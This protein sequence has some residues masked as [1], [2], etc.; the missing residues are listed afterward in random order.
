LKKNSHTP[1]F[2]LRLLAWF[3]PPNLYESIEGDLLEQFEG[4]RDIYGE[5]RAK[6]RLAW[7]VFLFFKLEII[8]RNRFTVRLINSNMTGNYFKVASRNILKRKV[9]SFITA[10][11]LSTGIAFCVLIY[12][13]I[14]DE[15]SF[16]QF[17]ENKHRIFRMEEKNFQYTGSAYVQLGL[18]QALKDE[19]PEVEFATRFVSGSSGYSGIFKYQD[20]IFSENITFADGDFFKMFSFR[21]LK[22]NASTL[23][24]QPDDVVITTTIAEKYFSADDPIGKAISIDIEGEK[25]FK[26]AGVIEPAPANSSLVYSIIV[27]QEVRPYYKQQLTRWGNFNT[28]TFVQ[29]HEGANLAQFKLN[30]DKLV[31]K[32]MSDKLEKWKKESSIPIPSNAKIFEYQFTPLPDIHLKK[33]IIWERVSDSKYSFILSGIALLILLIACINY[34]SLSLTTSASRKTE[35][36]I[37][38]AIGAFNRQLVYQ[39]SVESVL[40]AIFSAILGLGFVVLALPLFNQFTTKSIELSIHNMPSVLAI[41][42]AIALFTGLLAGSYP[43]FFLSRFKPALVLKGGFTSH[44]QSGFT[45]PL[46]VLQFALSSFLMISSAIMYQQMKY[47]TTKDL[48][49]DQHQVIVIPTQ[50]NWSEESN[51]TVQQF[52]ARL[53]QEPEVVSVAGTSISFNKGWSLNGYKINDEDK[54]AYVYAVDPEYIPT[55]GMQLVMGRNFDPERTGDSTAVIVNEAL[56]KDMKWKNPLN[57]YLNWTGDEVGL[58][59]KVIGVVKDY[60]FRSLE[61]AIEP[62]LLSMDKN[63]AGYLVSMHVKIKPGDIPSKVD[64]IRKAW[65]EL[66]PDRPFDFVFLDSDVAL[67]YESY[68]RWMNMMGLATLFGILISCLG[69]FGLA[70]ISAVNRTKEIGIRK[71]MGADLSNLFIMLNKQFIWLSLIAFAFAAPLSWYVMKQW[72][73]S[74]QFSIE[75]RWELFAVSL[76]AGLLLALVTVSYHAVKASLLNPAETLKNE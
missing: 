16:D 15:K 7:N 22:G 38:K 72:L 28:P 8:L 66:F 40:I 49:Y 67:Q 56:V 69:L 70:G 64:K 23:F 17:H 21:L 41:S 18:M 12:L 35:V 10:F 44:L 71:V 27:P 31:Q 51:R 52:R 20:K 37:R 50:K 55:L 47:I 53:A 9:Y 14:L 58:G 25:I 11:G 57:E 42:L 13:F 1:P 24:K 30:L 4:D 19:L 33:E 46:V 34:I 59:S 61:S 32:F 68:E 43:A 63:A 39:F 54:S 26:V 75:L 2:A 3:C 76:V 29:L 48:G 36:G 74:F 65:M 45:K 73:S 60:H 62:M 6:R 5:R